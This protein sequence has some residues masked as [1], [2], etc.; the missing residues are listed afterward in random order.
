MQGTPLSFHSAH[1][2]PAILYKFVSFE[3]ARKILSG[4]TVRYTPRPELN[5]VAEVPIVLET[6]ESV[7]ARG[8]TLL[9][10]DSTSRLLASYFVLSQNAA[11]FKK[12]GF[13]CLTETQLRR[14]TKLLASFN[15]SSSNSLRTNSRR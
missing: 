12:Y 9:G 4:L 14:R 11:I 2:I 6:F 10:D 3:T 1:V 15:P 8:R 7:E 13:L 5:D